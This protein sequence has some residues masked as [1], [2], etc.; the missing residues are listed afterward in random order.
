MPPPQGHQHAEGQD[1]EEDQAAEGGLEPLAGLVH[2]RQSREQLAAAH[3][4]DQHG[5]NA[6]VATHRDHQL[7]CRQPDEHQR[8]QRAGPGEGSDDVQH[9]AGRREGDLNRRPL[10]LGVLRDCRWHDGQHCQD[11]QPSRTGRRQ[12]PPTADRHDQI[13]KAAAACAAPTGVSRTQAKTARTEIW[14]R[15]VSRNSINRPGTMKAAATAQTTAGQWA[16]RSQR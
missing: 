11:E 2:F 3:D 12:H 9:H 15:S 13:T 5:R 8:G 7:I 6:A 4:Q 16:R 1:L 10:C 14:D